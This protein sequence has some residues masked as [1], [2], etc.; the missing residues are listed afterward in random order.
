MRKVMAAAA[1]VALGFAVPAEARNKKQQ[2]Q[3]EVTTI[4]RREL[5]QMQD[6]LAH[7]QRQLDVREAEIRMLR[8]GGTNDAGVGGAGMAGAP[9]G[10]IYQGELWSVSFDAKEIGLRVAPDHVMLFPITRKTE[11]YRNGK[12]VPLESIRQGTPVRV[13]LPLAAQKDH[14]RRPVDQIVIEPAAKAPKG[15]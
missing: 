14:G 9:T 12:R 11:A 4:E 2:Q 6:L 3:P 7:Q 1:V 15:R 10:T 5:A 13:S 8:Q